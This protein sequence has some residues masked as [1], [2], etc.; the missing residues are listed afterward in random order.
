MQP[1]S[2]PKGTYGQYSRSMSAKLQHWV[3]EESKWRVCEKSLPTEALFQWFEVQVGRLQD[4]N[5]FFPAEAN[6]HDSTTIT[7]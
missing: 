6:E 5:P 2:F 1:I 7:E 3:T 4:S